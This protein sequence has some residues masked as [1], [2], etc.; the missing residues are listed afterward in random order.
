MSSNNLFSKF[1]PS[2]KSE[3]LAKI[4]R[5]LRGRSV[6]ELDWHLPNHDDASLPLASGQVRMSPFAHAEDL[7]IAPEPLAGTRTCNTWEIGENISVGDDMKAANTL[8]LTGL[9]GGVNAPCFV[10]EDNFPSETQLNV[11]L[12]NIELN[13]ISIFFKEKTENR[14]PLAFLKSLKN[15]V[16]KSDKNAFLRSKKAILYC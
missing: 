9:L 3:W 13:Y 1:T 2:T 8:A 12:T 4:N 5:D 16:G 11:L 10:F 14:S 6:E 7:P 15:K